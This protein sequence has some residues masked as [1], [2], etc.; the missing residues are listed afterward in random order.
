MGK[1]DDGNKE[2]DLYEEQES[3]DGDKHMGLSPS[4]SGG[5]FVYVV[6]SVEGVFE[7]AVEEVAEDVC[8][9]GER[10]CEG[11]EAV[12]GE[13]DC[14]GQHAVGSGEFLGLFIPS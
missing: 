14:E 11:E 9:G 8:D 5:G 12:E 10:E 4:D 13:D 2:D 1:R 6:A 3:K 7:E